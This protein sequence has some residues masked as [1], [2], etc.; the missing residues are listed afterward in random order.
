VLCVFN[1]L[2]LPP[3]DGGRVLVGLLPRALALPLARAE[4][5]GIMILLLFLFILPMIGSQAGVNLNL[6]G[7]VIAGP[8]NALI[9]FV[10]LVTGQGG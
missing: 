3:L 7:Y 5:Y 6:L 2:P 10:L 9:N 8:T 1:M 4:P